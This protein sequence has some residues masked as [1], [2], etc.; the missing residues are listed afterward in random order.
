M[1]SSRVFCHSLRKYASASRASGGRATAR[2][3][4]L[5]YC[6]DARPHREPRRDPRRPAGR[7][8]PTSI[9]RRCSRRRPPPA[10][11]AVA[12]GPEVAGRHDPRQ[13]RAPPGARA[14]SRPRG[15]TNKVASL[16]ADE[17]GARHR[18]AVGRQRRPG[19][20]LGRAAK[21]ACT[22]PSSCRPRRSAR[23]STRCLGYGAEVVLHGAH[24]GETLQRVRELEA[25]RGLVYCHP[26]DD[27]AVIAGHG[28]AGPRDPR[29]PARRRCRRRRCRRRRPHQ[30]DR[31]GRQGAAA[32][33]PRLR[34]RARGR[35]RGR[36]WPSSA[37][38]SSR[39]SRRPSP[40]GWPR[41]FAGAWTLAMVQRYLDGLVLLDDADDPGRRPVRRRADEAGPGAGRRR[42]PGGRPVRPD[43]DPGR[44]AGL[45]RRL[46]RQRR[47]RTAGRS[48]SRW[49]RTCRPEVRDPASDRLLHPQL[50]EPVVVDAQVVGE[51]VEDRDPDLVREVVE[52]GEVLLER[53]PEEA[54]LVRDRERVRAPLDPRDALVQAV[55]R[56][57][58]VQVVVAPLLGG[59]LVLDDDR[60]LVECPVERRRDVGEDALDDALEQVVGRARRPAA[61]RAGLGSGGR[62][63]SRGGAWASSAYPTAVTAPRR[64]TLRRRSPRCGSTRRAVPPPDPS[65][66]PAGLPRHGR[67]RGPAPLPRL[68]RPTDPEATARRRHASRRPSCS[69]TASPRRRRSGRPWRAACARPRRVV[70]M[71]LRGHGLSDSPTHG[72]DPATLAGDVEAV[73]D[74]SGRGRGTA[75]AGRPRRA[76]LRRDRRGVGGRPA[77]RP[78]R[79]P[80]PRRR[81]LGGRRRLERA[82][83]P[84]SSSARSRSRPRSSARWVPTWPIA[85]GVRSA[86]LGRR[87]GGRRAGRGRGG[88]GRQGRAR[89]PAARP[90]R[91][92][93]E[94]MFALPSARP[95]SRGRRRPDR[96]AHRRPT[97]MARDRAA[98]EDVAR[99]RSS[100]PAGR[101]SRLVDLRAV[102]HNLMRYRPAAVAA[103]I[104]AVD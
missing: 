17:R 20:R 46:R 36:P 94:A 69:S 45:R 81:R 92:P 13:G 72:Y 23:R 16:T 50:V 4:P 71:D 98:L 1:P 95:S 32:G 27:P 87:P 38:R 55:Q 14:R 70:A 35:E 49:R 85:R 43:P 26:F 61:G 30:R 40:T 48:S 60:D 75:G 65:A 66:E 88:A 25:E 12:G 64:R 39:S 11:L 84:T 51:L 67:R 42:R 7:G 104:L 54:D 99:G 101:R 79:R 96:R 62:S 73:V 28:S 56:L 33:G 47:D 37:A 89:R 21:P 10:C 19:L 63:G 74:A 78:L 59:R 97:T 53:D 29:R 102:G 18:H 9:G 91:R 57:V 52:V 103:A 86:D 77:R 44:R 58:A 76:R 31:R 41:P 80:R 90:R 6:A 83:T 5:R 93:S 3:G 100:A 82:S 24:V 22:R 15:M 2:A 34:R 8:R 68:G